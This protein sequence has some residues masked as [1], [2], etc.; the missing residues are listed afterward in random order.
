MVCSKIKYKKYL[1]ANVKGEDDMAFGVEHEQMRQK[2]NK[3]LEQILVQKVGKMVGEELWVSRLHY[4]IKKGRII[5]NMFQ[6]TDRFNTIY[7]SLVDE[8]T[9][10]LI[11]FKVEYKY[12]IGDMSLL[13][14]VTDI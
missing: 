9:K 6:P 12:N 13:T 5:I 3:E 4:Y 14:E 8:W 11:H 2:L 7:Y 1:F 10:E